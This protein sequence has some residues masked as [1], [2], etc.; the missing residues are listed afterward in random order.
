MGKKRM[1]WT[2][3]YMLLYMQNMKAMIGDDEYKASEKKWIVNIIEIY[4][5]ILNKQNEH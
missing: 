3:P 5:Y 1:W 2:M 4:E